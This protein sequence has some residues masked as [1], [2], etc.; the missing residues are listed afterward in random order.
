MKIEERRDADFSSFSEPL[1][2]AL[3]RATSLEVA[4]QMFCERFYAEFA[5]SAVLV[6][7]FVTLPF[8]L[9]PDA[10]SAFAR[11]AAE[12][13]GHAELLAADTPVLTLLG[14]Y[15]IEP[16]WRQRLASRGHLAIPPSPQRARGEIP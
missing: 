15:G 11:A 13:T 1:A 12:R 3:A 14:S 2:S 7:S 9:L 6:R 8:S 16:A 5:E 4:A 10:E